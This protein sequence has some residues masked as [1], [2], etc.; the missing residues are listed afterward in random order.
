M[1]SMYLVNRNNF[2]PKN[3][4]LKCVVLH[5]YFYRNKCTIIY[6]YRYSSKQLY[7]SHLINKKTMIENYLRHFEMTY[8]GIH[9]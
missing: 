2:F 4:Q 5:V 1:D 9:Q 3:K 7:T 6:L 8:F